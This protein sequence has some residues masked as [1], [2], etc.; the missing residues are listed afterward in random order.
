MAAENPYIFGDPAMDRRRLEA[1]TQLF[2]S[3][4]R[5][6]A[7]RLAGRGVQR[8]LDIGCGE[9]QLGLVLRD[10]Y[11]PQAQLVGIDKDERAIALARAHAREQGAAN[12]EF[13]VGDVMAG[14]PPGPFDLVYDSLVLVHLH[15]PEKVIAAAWAVLKPGGSFWVKEVHPQWMAATNQ[16]SFQKLADYMMATATAIGG[17]PYIGGDLPRLLAAA[18]FIDIREEI[19][20]YPL[21]GTTPEG[22]A[23]LATQLG[24][25][26]NARGMISRMQ[27]VTEREI[28]RLYLDVCNAALRSSQALG[29]EPFINFIARRPPA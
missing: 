28:E 10:I 18:G 4:I 15:E 26:H 25:F 7:V 16:R 22:R 20:E 8:I 17:H 3:F 6:N 21:G 23:M 14:L 11:A 2:S 24:V 1:Q 13:V 9:G 19:E 5:A 29:N 12:V 27:K